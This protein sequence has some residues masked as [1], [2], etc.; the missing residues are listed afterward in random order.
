MKLNNR[1]SE[2][3][4]RA[5]KMLQLREKAM[6]RLRQIAIEFLFLD[7]SEDR[8]LIEWV[9]DELNGH[10]SGEI[11]PNDQTLLSE[12]EDPETD[13]D[14]RK[15]CEEILKSAGS[16]MSVDEMTRQLLDTVS[17][18]TIP[19]DT[20]P[21]DTISVDTISVDGEKTDNRG[22]LFGFMKSDVEAKGYG[23]ATI[24]TGQ[25]GQCTNFLREVDTESI[26]VVT[27]V[28]LVEGQLEVSYETINFRR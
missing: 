6:L 7:R 10:S 9:L 12:I 25:N 27:N 13:F 28:K 11:S 17:P 14:I 8:E 4:T 3:Q 23:L 16:T 22:S 2:M 26:R 24:F 19:A 18:D 20:I 1:D 15:K 21:A 5:E